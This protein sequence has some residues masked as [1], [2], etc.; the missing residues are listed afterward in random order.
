MVFNVG[1]VPAEGTWTWAYKTCLATRTTWESAV[2]AQDH[3]P[4]VVQE[5]ALRILL[6]EFLPRTE[7]FVINKFED[8]R[9]ELEEHFRESLTKSERRLGFKCIAVRTFFPERGNGPLMN[10]PI[11]MGWADTVLQNLRRGQSEFR[12][13]TWL[14]GPQICV[15][16]QALISSNDPPADSRRPR[17]LPIALM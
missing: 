11:V 15:G 4:V 17:F 7:D 5:K 10:S 14:E 6:Q 8:T 1:I 3:G 16:V 9:T 13:L 2:V 12:S